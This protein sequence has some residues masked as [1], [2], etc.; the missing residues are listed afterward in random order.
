M[1]KADTQ[2]S[3]LNRTWRTTTASGLYPAQRRIPPQVPAQPLVSGPAAGTRVTCPRR[4][5]A[6]APYRPWRTPRLPLPLHP[7]QSPDRPRHRRIGP[8]C[9][10]SPRVAPQHYSIPRRPPLPLG[11][12]LLRVF[13]RETADHWVAKVVEAWRRPP[14]RRT[15]PRRRYPLWAGPRRAPKGVWM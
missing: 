1:K 9:T 14:L 3:G 6:V 13:G 10:Q 5:P 15:W 7:F 12:H 11:T 2:S 8:G 4:H